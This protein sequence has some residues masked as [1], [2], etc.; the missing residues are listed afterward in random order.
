LALVAGAAAIVKEAIASAPSA[1]LLVLYG[2]GVFGVF[3]VGVLNVLRS[4]YRDSKE[5]ARS[6]PDDLRGCL[7]VI[8]R[9][10]SGYKGVAVPPDGWLR[11]TVHRVDGAELEQVVDY[12]GSGDRGAG[13]RLPA[14]AGL[15]GAALAD[16]GK[17]PLVFSRPEDWPWDRWVEYLEQN[18]RMPRSRAVQTRTDRFSFMAVCLRNLRGNV[19]GVVYADAAEAEFFDPVAQGIFVY[20][21]IGLANWV[22]ERYA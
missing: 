15:V 22:D 4:H 3:A 7:H 21:C 13:R 1:I 14:T 5:E 9:V 20:G 8:L 11:L 16:V 19:T 17:R 2:F 10:M 6:A 12:V 18:M